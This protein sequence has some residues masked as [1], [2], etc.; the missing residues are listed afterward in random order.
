MVRKPRTC[1]RC[2]GMIP[3]ERMMALPET[4][5]CLKCSEAVGSDFIV[6]FCRV[7]LGKAGSL[8]KNY[9]DWNLRKVRRYIEPLD[10][11][12]PVAN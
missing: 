4:R 2:L 1:L 6:Y 12:D 3:V 8:K 5:L 10:K 11:Q 7:S 9:G